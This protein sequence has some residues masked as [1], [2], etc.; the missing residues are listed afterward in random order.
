MNGLHG[1]YLLTSTW[2]RI[3]NR[4]K[5]YSLNTGNGKDAKEEGNVFKHVK[6]F[7]RFHIVVPQ[8][9][10]KEMSNAEKAGQK[11]LNQRTKL[12]H[13]KAAEKR[14]MKKRI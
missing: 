13:R 7:A 12:E 10:K 1:L 6:F 11:K 3:E 4:G 9:A 8:R 14:S 5:H 2:H